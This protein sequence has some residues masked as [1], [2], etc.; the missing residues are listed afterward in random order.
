MTE[1][2]MTM[3]IR[4]ILA[5]TDFSDLSIRA[6]AFAFELAQQVGANLILLQAIEVPPYPSGG[7]MPPGGRG[8]PSLT[9]TTLIITISASSLSIDPGLM[10][11][12][13]PCAFLT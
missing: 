2:G 13:R 4:R 3:Q 6:V 9:F 8:R 11:S 5:P 7:F 1:E 12:L 10:N